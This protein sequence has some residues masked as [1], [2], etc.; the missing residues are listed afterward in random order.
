MF[1]NNSRASLQACEPIEPAI[2]P[3]H[4]YSE[5]GSCS[6]IRLHQA[7]LYPVGSAAAVCA[8]ISRVTRG[9]SYQQGAAAACDLTS[10]KHLLGWT[11]LAGS[12][13]RHDCPKEGGPPAATSY[14][15]HADVS[16]AL[17]LRMC[18]DGQAAMACI[19]QPR[20]HAN[21]A[22]AP[23]RSGYRSAALTRRAPCAG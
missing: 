13:R 10:V 6:C 9:G 12:V 18:H 22:L 16:L 23:C 3:V 11:C 7:L 5:A 17:V 21:G 20:V 14:V 19:S 2:Q 8:A 1:L 4:S 15:P